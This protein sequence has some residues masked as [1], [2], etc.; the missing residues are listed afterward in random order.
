MGVLG[1]GFHLAR[2]DMLIEGLGSLSGKLK[3]TFDTDKKKCCCLNL[4]GS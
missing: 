1:L 4:P 2:K 3:T